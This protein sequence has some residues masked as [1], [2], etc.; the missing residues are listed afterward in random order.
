MSDDNPEVLYAR[1]WRYQ[2]AVCHDRVWSKGEVYLERYMLEMFGF[3]LRLHIFHRSDPDRALHDHPWW[4]ITFPLNSYIERVPVDD[5]SHA[6]SGVRLVG[7][8]QFHF[9][10]ATYRH[11]VLVQ[12]PTRTLVLTGR[13]SRGWGFWPDGKFIPWR[14]YVE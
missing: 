2:F 11:R 5:H 1:G 14:E 4:F 9:R 3:S 8:R 13:R 7:R 12:R 6:D 10:P